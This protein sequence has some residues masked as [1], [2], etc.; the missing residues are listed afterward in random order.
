[1][2]SVGGIAFVAAIK[3]SKIRSLSSSLPERCKSDELSIVSSTLFGRAIM[4]SSKWVPSGGEKNSRDPPNA[5][6]R[7]I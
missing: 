1:M 4:P 2:S 5:K 6:F 7:L 3:S